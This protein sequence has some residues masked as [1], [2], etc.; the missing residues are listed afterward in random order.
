[1]HAAIISIIAIVVVVI[2]YKWYMS[3]EGAENGPAQPSTTPSAPQMPPQPVISGSD[4]GGTTGKQVYLMDGAAVTTDANGT[5]VSPDS[6]THM[7][8][9]AVEDRRR[10]IL[11][12][13]ERSKKS[14]RAL[15]DRMLVDEMKRNEG[16]QKMAIGDED[17]QENNIDCIASILSPDDVIP[18]YIPGRRT[19]V[20][21][22]MS[23]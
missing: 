10:K 23:E 3:K 8:V 12:P 21:L 9:N 2:L 15:S 13:L 19:L 5:N 11:N 7:T 16:H 6:T 4:Y 17:V 18:G 20:A 22:A 14:Q 1:M